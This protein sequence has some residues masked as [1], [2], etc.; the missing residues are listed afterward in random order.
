MVEWIRDRDQ[1]RTVQQEH[2]DFFV[3]VFWGE[4]S[5]AAQRALAELEEFSRE[6]DEVPVYAVDVMELRGLHEE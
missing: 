5:E 6:Q 1:L 3:L 4:F 2:R